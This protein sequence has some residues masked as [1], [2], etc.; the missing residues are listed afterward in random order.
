MK[1]KPT[2]E[3]G[4]MDHVKCE[5]GE[6]SLWHCRAKRGHRATCSTVPY[7]VCAGNMWPWDFND[8]F[9]TVL[10]ALSRNDV[11]NVWQLFLIFI[12]TQEVWMWNSWTV[13]ENAPGG[14]QLKTRASGNE[15]V[16]LVGQTKIQTSSANI[17][18]VEIRVEETI[19]TNS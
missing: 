5:R 12:M 11:Q 13:L 1:L 7:V 9:C 17:L 19:R 15:S 8:L 10:M 6:A 4:F 3:S 14:W 18:S 16:L 2:F